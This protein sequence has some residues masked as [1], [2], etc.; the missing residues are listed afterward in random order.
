MGTCLDICSMRSWTQPLKWTDMSARMYTQD[1]WTCVIHNL[2][3]ISSWSA[4]CTEQWRM[5][6]LD[7]EAL[8]MERAGSQPCWFRSLS[9]LPKT[10]S[11][12]CW[13]LPNS[14]MQQQCLASQSLVQERGRCLSFAPGCEALVWGLPYNSPGDLVEGRLPLTQPWFSSYVFVFEKRIE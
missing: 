10:H 11:C 14:L 8:R 12:V 9:C 4:Y 7:W 3:P 13:T 5:A 1:P 2:Q 6:V